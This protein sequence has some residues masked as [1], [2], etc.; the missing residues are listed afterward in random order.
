MR[1][2]KWHRDEIILALDLYF[3]PDRGSIDQNNPKIIALSA[4]LN[5]L[6]IF[7]ERPDKEKFR[8]A[9]GVTFKLSNFLSID[10]TYSGKGMSN[11]SILDRQVFEEFENNKDLLRKL[12]AEIRKLVNDPDILKE[13]ES[14]KVLH[15]YLQYKF[16]GLDGP[17]LLSLAIHQSYFMNNNYP[18]L[19]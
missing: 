14:I 8:N 9:S 16:F 6:P 10:S 11:G 1:N 19:N 13:L 4:L 15:F 17:E 18:S 7:T 2:S 12:A 3:Q 5:Q